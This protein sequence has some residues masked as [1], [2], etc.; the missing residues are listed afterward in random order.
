MYS[1]AVC[2]VLEEIKSDI[3]EGKISRD[4][5]SKNLPELFLLKGC[6]ETPDWR[7][8]AKDLEMFI[9][10]LCLPRRS[11]KDAIAIKNTSKFKESEAWLLPE[12]ER[13]QA[14]LLIGYCGRN[15]QLRHWANNQ[16]VI[17]GL[18]KFALPE[19]CGGDVAIFRRLLWR[20]VQ[21]HHINSKL[22]LL[23]RSLR[24][25]CPVT[26]WVLNYRD[27]EMARLIRNYLNYCFDSGLFE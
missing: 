14:N 10:Y 6:T 11:I 19:E 16:G 17:L 3:R 2:R 23:L 8:I 7:V 18:P 9:A 13:D 22:L 1:Q 5:A 4:I 24:S 26:L 27:V 15:E 20:D 25:G 12:K 21:R